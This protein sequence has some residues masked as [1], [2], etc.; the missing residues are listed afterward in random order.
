MSSITEQLD[1]LIEPT[2]DWKQADFALGN[3]DSLPQVMFMVN[4]YEEMEVTPDF[5]MDMTLAKVGGDSSTALKAVLAL[6]PKARLS[7]DEFP[8]F[9]VI[10]FVADGYRKMVPDFAAYG[11]G[12]ELEA[13][14]KNL[15]GSD[16]TEAITIV[17]AEDNLVGGVDMVAA[18][19]PYGVGDMGKLVFDTP[20]IHGTD[21]R[22]EGRVPDI[23]R[24]AFASC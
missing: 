7:D 9:R 15:P 1:W 5:I 12:E 20:T 19:M 11:N 17:V 23:I 24:E 14:F 22:H 16:V 6:V 3:R 10:I 4:G 2:M 8:G 13:E 21:E 18:E